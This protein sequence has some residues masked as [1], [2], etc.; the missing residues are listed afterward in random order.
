MKKIRKRKRMPESQGAVLPPPEVDLANV[1]NRMCE[2]LVSLENKV[3][4]LINRAANRPAGGDRFQRTA[5]RFTRPDRSRERTFTQAVCAEC[6]KNC[7]VPFKP[8]G[9]RPVY[10]RDCFSA[11]KE[12]GLSQE[13]SGERQREGS[14]PNRRNFDNREEAKDHRQNKKRGA[15]FQKRKHRKSGAFHK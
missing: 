6:G 8:T 12:S 10:C 11:R 1:V 15:F 4:I 7:E 5:T 2:L 13:K 3:D 14:F 9:D